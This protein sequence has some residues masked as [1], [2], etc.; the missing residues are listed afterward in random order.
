MTAA[1]DWQWL[2]AD[3]HVRGPL[4]ITFEYLGP[5]HGEATPHVTVRV[6]MPTLQACGGDEPFLIQVDR[7]IPDKPDRADRVRML[8]AIA[9]ELYVHELAEQFT[10]GPERPFAPTHGDRA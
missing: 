6:T 5:S 3:T 8:M 10:S 1:R 9:A 4:P 7:T 2:C